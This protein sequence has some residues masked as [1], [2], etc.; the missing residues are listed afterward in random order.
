M[1]RLVSVQIGDDFSRSQAR[2]PSRWRWN[3][4]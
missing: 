3:Q 2:L 1:E 4:I